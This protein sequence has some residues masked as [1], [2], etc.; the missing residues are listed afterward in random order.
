MELHAWA[1]GCIRNHS[2]PGKPPSAKMAEGEASDRT[3]TA[4]HSRTWQQQ[5]RQVSQ[6]RKQVA[7]ESA[8]STKHSVKYL[9][10]RSLMVAA[11]NRPDGIARVGERF[12]PQSLI[13]RQAALGENGRSPRMPG[14]RPEGAATTRRSV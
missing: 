14:C 8:E 6:E 3:R 2:C 12:Y 1:S 9:C 4:A 7:D 5:V 10:I 11:R 13:P